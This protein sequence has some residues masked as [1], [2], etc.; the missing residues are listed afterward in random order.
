[1]HTFDNPRSNR[2]A[3][4]DALG[5]KDRVVDGKLKAEKAVGLKIEKLAVDQ[6]AGVDKEGV[7]G[8]NHAKKILAVNATLKG[9]MKVNARGKFIIHMLTFDI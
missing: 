5:L 8:K 2:E 7:N 6:A 4:K 3:L 1:M 9:G